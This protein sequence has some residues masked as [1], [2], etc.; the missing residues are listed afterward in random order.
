[1]LI[2]SWRAPAA[3]T[4]MA[5]AKIEEYIEIDAAEVM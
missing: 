4:T 1:M 3:R 2:Y 5:V